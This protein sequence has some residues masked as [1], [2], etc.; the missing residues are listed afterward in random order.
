MIG[1]CVPTTDPIAPSQ[2]YVVHAGHC[3]RSMLYYRISSND[4]SERMPLMGRTVRHEEAV[5]LI[6]DWINSLPDTCQ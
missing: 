1:F 6:G 5:Q 4:P 2:D 3:E